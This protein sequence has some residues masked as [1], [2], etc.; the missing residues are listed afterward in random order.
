LV[1]RCGPKPT[2]AN[3][4][5]PAH[6]ASLYAPGGEPLETAGSDQFLP[7]PREVADA[8]AQGREVWRY[9]ALGADPWRVLAR[10]VLVGG[11]LV[12]VLQVGRS[13]RPVERVVEQLGILLATVVPLTVVLAGAGGLFL[14]GR[15][16]D[17]IDRLTRTAAAISADDLTRRLPVETVRRPDELGR[18]AAT[19]NLMLDRLADSFRRQRQFTADASHE[20]RTPLTRVLSQ[21]DVTLARPR[22]ADEYE[23][24]LASVRE[25]VLRLR[26]LVDA[27]LMLARADA[28]Q[29]VLVRER[30]DLGELAE[31]IV[32]A[33]QA[34]A[35][36]RGVE[37]TVSARSGVVV[38]GDQAHLMQLVVNLVDNA[39][40]HTPAGGKVEMVVD[41]ETSESCPTAC[42]AVHDTGNGIAP[43]H[44]P[45]VFE[46][47]YQAEPERAAGGAGL[48]LAICRSIAEAH[49]GQ[50]RVQSRPGDGSTF[51]V[52]LPLD[53]STT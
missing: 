25:D 8:V 20:L 38:A 12:A 36:E 30:I 18:L 42:L 31:Q 41:V 22:S 6:I 4:L 34:A 50:I 29:D 51:S 28:R 3:E 17:P 23:A 2:S 16:L 52:L 7:L 5:P 13:E 19:F 47:F 1:A 10:P 46:R 26:R 43:E 53:A 45:H 32:D 49:G 33:M 9:V 27:L 44:L 39:L 40:K 11:R 35:D 14:A 21:A 37:L 15:A 48:G 24:V